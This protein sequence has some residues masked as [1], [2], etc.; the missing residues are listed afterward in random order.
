MVYIFQRE[1]STLLIFCLFPYKQLFV[2]QNVDGA[3]NALDQVF[4]FAVLDMP[5]HTVNS[6]YRQLTEETGKK[7]AKPRRFFLKRKEL[8]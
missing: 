7:W 8:L 3:E 4:A 5:D 1:K 6:I 2:N